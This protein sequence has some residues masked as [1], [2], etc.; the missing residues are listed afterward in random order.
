GWP[1]GMK[2]TLTITRPDAGVGN[3][4]SKAGLGAPGTLGADVIPARQATLQALETAQGTPVVRY[5]ES[6][7]DLLDD[8]ENTGGTFEATATFG[9]AMSDALT[10]EGNYTFLAKATY[11]DECSGM[12]EL[13][14]SIHVDVGIDPGKTTVTTTP[15]G[16][17]PDGGSCV[18]MTFTPRDKYDNLLGPGR[19]D[20]FAVE[21]QPG[22]MP[23]SVVQDL[24]N[25]S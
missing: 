2:A 11:G 6:T 25:G 9:R 10:V 3:L 14:W 16:P 21:P 17:R 23:S 18:R 12:R 5:T 20:S 7:I 8:S 24:G 4:L 22:S 15:L 1:D 13:A 19:S